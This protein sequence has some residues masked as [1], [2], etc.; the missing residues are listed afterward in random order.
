MHAF[1]NA[2]ADWA[3][4]GIK[5]AQLNDSSRALALYFIFYFSNF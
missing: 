1:K 4:A 5:I 3:R 2:S